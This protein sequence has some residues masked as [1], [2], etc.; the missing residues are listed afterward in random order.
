M[1]KVTKELHFC[2]GHRLMQYQGKCRVPHG[3]NAKVAI[4]LNTPGFWDLV[5]AAVDRLGKSLR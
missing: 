2:Y 4:D 5:V 1:Y 3:H